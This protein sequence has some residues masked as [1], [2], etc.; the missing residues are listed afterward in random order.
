M[1]DWETLNCVNHPDRIAIERCEVCHKPLCAYCLYYAEDGTRLC[2]EHADVARRAGM[3][4]EEPGAYAE[5]LIGAQIGMQ[6][7][8]KHGQ[9]H[10]EAGLYKGNSTDLMS[11]VGMLFGL[12]AFGACC[13]GAYCFPVVGFVLSLIALINARDSYD[14]RRTRR[15]G[16]IGLLASGV[17][18][19]AVVA[20]IV[21]YVMALS[22][23]ITTWN[24]STPYTP[25]HLQTATPPTFTPEPGQDAGDD[26]VHHSPPTQP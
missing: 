9:T 3:R 26:V 5:Q 14:K 1:N 15:L 10:S 8:Q 21:V 13:G 16:L 2:E 4:I 22:G 7:K 19:L 24:F 17:W 11:L 20:C 12:M 18:M 25:Q 6:H 23:S